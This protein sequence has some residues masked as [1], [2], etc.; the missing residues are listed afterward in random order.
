[1]EKLGLLVSALE[2]ENKAAH[3]LIKAYRKILCSTRQVMERRLPSRVTESKLRN[4][5]DKATIASMVAE[6]TN[7]ERLYSPHMA[8]VNVPR[9]G[10]EQDRV[11]GSLCDEVDVLRLGQERGYTTGSLRAKADVPG[12]EEE[13][14][15]TQGSLRAAEVDVLRL[16]QERGHTNGSPYP[17]VDWDNMA[18]LG[19][20]RGRLGLSLPS[21]DN[22]PVQACDPGPDH[23][24]QTYNPMGGRYLPQTPNVTRDP[25]GYIEGFW[26][27]ITAQN[28]QFLA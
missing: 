28:S 12:P 23:P 20:T 13:R 21:P 16:G 15:C 6:L 14:G 27:S 5:H 9:P 2:M 8:E 7:L 26:V 22:L 3:Q 4:T 19:M 18:R 11:R 17:A 24:H 1:M 25:F 10:E